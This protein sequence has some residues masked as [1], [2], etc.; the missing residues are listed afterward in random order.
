MSWQRAVRTISQRGSLRAL[1]FW[2]FLGT[3]VVAP[4][5]YGGTTAWAIELISLLLA[6]A[7]VLWLASLAVDRRLPM[8][9]R[10]LAISA[11]A[12]LL[13]GWWMEL[14]A[15]GVYDGTFRT[16][17]SVEPLTPQLAGSSDSVLSFAMMVRV[18][19][20]VGVIVLVSEMVQRSVWLFRLWSALAICGGAI[21]LLGLIQKATTAPMIFWKPAEL[22]ETKTFFATYYYHANAGA[23]LNLVLP[24]VIGLS[25]WMMIARHERH[26]ARGLLTGTAIIVGVAIVSNTSRMAQIVGG[27][28]IVALA[29]TVARPLVARLVRGD[30]KTL[31]TGVIVVA[32]VIVAVAQATHLDQPLRRWQQF[33]KQLPVDERWSANRAALTALGDAG[34][35]GFGP[36]V[37]RAIFPHYQQKF[38]GELHGTWRF[39][40]DDYLQT[41]LEWGW[42][43]GLALGALS[44]GGMALAA[45]NYLRAETWS[46]RQR[47]LLFCSLLGLA[48][49]AL[50]AA[51]DF[52]LQIYSIQLLVATYLGVCWG[53]GRW[54]RKVESRN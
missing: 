14:N 53:S 45:R 22:W 43:G 31:V 41:L 25:C 16:F 34:A 37:F 54:E 4:W 12:I 24:A 32:I 30:K 44:F 11:G 49:V 52:P 50:H 10:G 46:N 26:V 8:V 42:M 19:M 29:G 17:V 47:I 51:V 9:P 18:T 28:L 21:A 1:A 35:L 3:L 5:F 27:L 36:G 6:L 15:H 40:H 39:L 38:R 23:F 33:A 7:L 20:L 48:G 2:V 13:L